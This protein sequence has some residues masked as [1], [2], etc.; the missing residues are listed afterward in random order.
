MQK[1]DKNNYTINWPLNLKKLVIG[2]NHIV[3]SS[4]NDAY[5][6]TDK[7]GCLNLEY[8]DLTL[9]PKLLHNLR[10]L[11]IESAGPI[12]ERSHGYGEK[13]FEFL[14]ANPH[15]KNLD[16]GFQSF[17]PELFEIIGKFNNLS[18][19]GLV[20][21]GDVNIE[22]FKGIKSPALGNLKNLSLNLSSNISILPIIVEQ[23][24]SIAKLNLT[25][26]FEFFG[27]IELL[28]LL[29]SEIQAFKS[30]KVLKL[31]IFVDYNLEILWRKLDDMEDFMKN[32]EA[33]PNLKNAYFNAVKFEEHEFYPELSPESLL[34]LKNNERYLPYPHRISFYKFNQ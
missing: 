25:C 1:F 19:L 8:N 13:Y 4:Y 22:S 33:C 21:R 32:L 27:D 2:S 26:D 12:Y 5:V 15:V 10:T 31:K 23:F 24:P 9:E 18:E 28:K 34:R 16:I 3:F 7:L 17:K 11:I 30:L 6:T 14:K 29:P 20:I